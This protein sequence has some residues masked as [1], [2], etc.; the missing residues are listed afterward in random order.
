MD[1]LK[2]KTREKQNP[3]G[4]DLGLNL[5]VVW[6]HRKLIKAPEQGEIIAQLGIYRSAAGA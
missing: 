2:D 3:K 6:M 5:R 1:Q 4:D